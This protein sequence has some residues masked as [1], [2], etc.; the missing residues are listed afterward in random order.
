MRHLF[1]N[2]SNAFLRIQNSPRVFLFFDY[3][4]TLTPIV[5]T[6]EEAKFP[7]RIKNLINKLKNHPKFTIAIISGRS[8]KNIKKMV[9]L[10][11]II[12][13]G[14]HG[15][16]IEGKGIKF[17]KPVIAHALRA[18]MKEI[19]VSLHR[20]LNNIKGARIEDKGV[21]LSVHYRLVKPKEAPLVKNRFKRIVAPFVRS[22]KVRL[23]SGKKV[24]EVR[25]EVDWNKGTAVLML[26]KGKKKTL[27]LYLGD[28][29]TDID[30]FRAVKGKGISIFVGSPKTSITAD[31]FLKNPKDVERFI[32]KLLGL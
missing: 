30:G 32:E 16:E 7:R 10:K 1:S 21:T 9:R 6:P 19:S 22:K 13:A 2:R 18:L 5:S 17:V 20:A 31:Y 15:L 23:S 11:G 12:Y 29:V 28:D 8:L 14:N 25:P 3:D 26:L 4:G 27:P 24:L